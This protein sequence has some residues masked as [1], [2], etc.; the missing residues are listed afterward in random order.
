MHKDLRLV[1]SQAHDVSVSMP[2]TAAAQQMYTAA[3]AKGM[4]ADFSI[5]IQFMEELAALSTISEELRRR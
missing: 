3:M 2:T 5:M 1:L 4:D